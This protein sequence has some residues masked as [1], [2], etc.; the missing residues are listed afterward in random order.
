MAAEARI[1]DSCQ[2]AKI[3]Y[4]RDEK[5]IEMNVEVCRNELNQFYAKKCKDGCEFSKVLKTTPSVKIDNAILG[6]LGGQLCRQLDMK[7]YLSEIQFGNELIENVS[8][9]FGS[10]PTAFVSN[11]FLVK[12]FADKRNKH[13]LQ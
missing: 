13:D 3:R 1:I 9:C 12:L 5:K 11:G 6:S 2:R 8:L 10:Y 7:N 4:Q